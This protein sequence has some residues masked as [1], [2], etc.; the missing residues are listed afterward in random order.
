MPGESA[1]ITAL[2]EHK[3]WANAASVVSIVLVIG[4]LCLTAYLADSAKADEASRIGMYIAM[5]SVVIVVCIW[6]AAAFIAAS[7][8]VALRRRREERGPW[9]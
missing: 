1:F 7:I 6:Q 5:V 9:E 8:E 4:L 3:R 2:R